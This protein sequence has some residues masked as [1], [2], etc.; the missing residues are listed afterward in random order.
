MGEQAV[1]CLIV[2]FLLLAPALL[3]AQTG[4]WLPPP[5]PADVCEQVEKNVRAIYVSWAS[6]ATESF[7]DLRKEMRAALA[8]K[9]AK[10]QRLKMIYEKLFERIEANEFSPPKFDNRVAGH[11]AAKKFAADQCKEEIKEGR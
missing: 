7:V 11:L 5:P 10:E 8:G 6:G 3:F 9:G 2:A 1:K 4:G